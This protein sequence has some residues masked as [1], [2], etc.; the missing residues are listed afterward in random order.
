MKLGWVG[1]WLKKETIFGL[2]FLKESIRWT[3][4]EFL[5]S[6]KGIMSQ[7]CGEG[8]GGFK[9]C[10]TEDFEGLSWSCWIC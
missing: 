1:G 6:L 10:V 7:M 4:I 5:L 8:L 2:E 9:N 3:M